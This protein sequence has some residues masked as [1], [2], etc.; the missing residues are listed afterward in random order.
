M[1]ICT[2]I[3]GSSCSASHARRARNQ[4]E[5]FRLIARALL[6][7]GSAVKEP[8]DFETKARNKVP[9][10]TSYRGAALLVRSLTLCFFFLRILGF[11]S[12]VPDPLWPAP[13]HSPDSAN[14]PSPRPAPLV[15]VRPLSSLVPYS[16]TRSLPLGLLPSSFC[17]R[18]RGYFFPARR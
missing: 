3:R 9:S 12:L 1:N 2:N 4:M 16:S 13:R 7:I 18:S 15:T 6:T 14:P 5:R 11:Q 8:R 10:A 17:R